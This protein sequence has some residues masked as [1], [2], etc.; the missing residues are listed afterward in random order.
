[1][2]LAVVVALRCV[3][4][5]LALLAGTR[6]TEVARAPRHLVVQRA[7]AVALRTAGVVLAHALLN[8]DEMNEIN[9]EK[10]LFFS[11]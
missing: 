3:S 9:P 4:V 6:R 2:H 8:R 10:N 5:A 1:M 7:A 11:F